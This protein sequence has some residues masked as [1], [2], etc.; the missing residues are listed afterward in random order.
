MTITIEAPRQ[1]EV[2]ALLAASE[3]F[4]FATYPAD[5][6]YL[7]DVS[8]L[9]A[10]GVTVWVARTDG[11]AL[12]MAALVAGEE[13]SE[14]KRLY[15]DDA[16]RGQGVAAALLGAIEQHAR[17][18]GTRIIRLETGPK[19]FAAIALYEKLGY[20]RIPNFGQYVGD[21]H[22]YCMEKAL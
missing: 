21:P 18:A 22:S 7:L 1:P 3:A 14:L 11:V 15:V 8:E 12:G 19:S 9:E 16:A 5:S 20:T 4:A 17:E 2:E 6:C 13:F 10:P